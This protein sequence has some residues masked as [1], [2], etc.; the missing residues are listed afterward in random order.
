MIADSLLK[1]RSLAATAPLLANLEGLLDEIHSDGWDAKAGLD[2]Y[3]AREV[4]SEIDA[5]AGRLRAVLQVAGHAT[6]EGLLEF[7]RRKPNVREAS[8][9][10]PCWIRCV[11]TCIGSLRFC[12][13]PS[14]WQSALPSAMR[15]GEAFPGNA[16][17]GC[18]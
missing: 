13:T 10:A 1:V 12:A 15:S 9:L 6:S 11:P 16:P 8:E 4:T 2:P 18:R 17:I 7:A 3:A 5:F 14:A